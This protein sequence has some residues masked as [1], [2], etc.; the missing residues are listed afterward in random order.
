MRFFAF[1]PPIVYTEVLKNF[2]CTGRG[3]SDIANHAHGFAHVSV[4]MQELDVLGT[5]KWFGISGY[6]RRDVYLS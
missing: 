4:A 6:A 1:F 2:G 5:L 3:S